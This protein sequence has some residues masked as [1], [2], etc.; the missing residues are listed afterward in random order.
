MSD[1]LFPNPI[2]NEQLRLADVPPR[3]AQWSEIVKRAH[4]FDGYKA[5]GSFAVC[6]TIA[7]E[8][9]HETLTDLRT[10]LFFEQ[11]RWNHFGRDP[12]AGAMEYIRSLLDQIKAKLS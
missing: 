7:N 5:H 2:D 11:R 9:R 8:R 3:S 10:Y 1:T 4:T 12:E 6:G